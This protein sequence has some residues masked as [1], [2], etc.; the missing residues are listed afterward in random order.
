MQ[1]QFHMNLQYLGRFDPT[2]HKL[3]K[4]VKNI[5]WKILLRIYIILIFTQDFKKSSILNTWWTKNT[6]LH[7]NLI[8]ETLAALFPKKLI[9]KNLITFDDKYIKTF[10]DNAVVT[11]QIQYVIQYL[12]NF[13]EIFN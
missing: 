6:I 9:I 13:Q 10:E 2:L 4:M 5:S 11:F 8:Q 12:L 1:M 7:W 3:K